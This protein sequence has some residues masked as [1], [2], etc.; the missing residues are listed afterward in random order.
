MNYEIPVTGCIFP[1]SGY[2]VEDGDF[3]Y[4]DHKKPAIE[5]FP[6]EGFWKKSEEEAYKTKDFSW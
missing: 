5:Q 6:N 2:F 1:S 3:K 4:E